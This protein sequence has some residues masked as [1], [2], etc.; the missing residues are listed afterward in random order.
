MDLL[1][2]H[3]YGYAWSGID[4]PPSSTLNLLLPKRVDHYNPVLWPAGRLWPG[5]PASL[6]LFSTM[7]TYIDSAKFFALYKKTTL[8]KLERERGLHIAHTYLEAFH[9]PAACLRGAT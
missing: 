9:P 1:V 5:M 8:D 2:K 3:G 7:M 4:V 6:W